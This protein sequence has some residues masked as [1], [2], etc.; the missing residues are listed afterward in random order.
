MMCILAAGN[1]E[2]TNKDNESTQALRETYFFVEE[3]VVGDDDK[4]HGN[5]CDECGDGG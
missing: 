3:V 5:G 2:N 1:K 4:N